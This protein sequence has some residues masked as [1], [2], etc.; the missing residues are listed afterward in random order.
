[1]LKLISQF[2][3]LNSMTITKPKK[4]KISIRIIA[5]LLIPSFV[6][7]T[8]PYKHKFTVTKNDP[9]KVLQYELSNGL[10]VYLSVNKDEPRISTNIALNTGSKNDPSEVTGLAHYLE[11]M[12]F[13]GTS[14]M[15]SLDWPKEKALLDQISAKYEEYRKT[16]DPAKRKTI[17]AEIDRLSGEAAKYVATNEYDQMIG[18]LGAK[19]TNAYTSLERTVYINDIPS[20]EL[21]KWM[22]IESE[23]FG[24]LTLR[25]FHTELEAV[26][27]E[28]NR[29]MD[30]DGRQANQARMQAL[31][32]N[33][34]YGTQ[35]TIGT[36]DHLKNPSMVKIHEYFNTYYVPNNMA[37]IMSGDLDPD[38]TIDLI[39]KYFGGM[40]MGAEP[41]Q[42]KDPGQPAIEKPQTIE[43]FGSEAEFISISYRTGG[44]ESGDQLMGDLATSVLSNG[45]A[46][47]IDKNMNQPQ[48]VI[49]AYAYSGG[50]KDYSQFTLGATPRA[51]QSLEEAQQLLL[52]QVELLKKGDFDEDLLKSIVRNAKK[53]QMQQAE[54]NGWKSRKMIDAFIYEMPWTYY[55]EYYNKMGEITKDKLVTWVNQKLQNN[56]IT[57]YKRQGERT[58]PKIEKP[59]I[60]PVTINR[61][62]KSDWRTNWEKT[63]SS[64]MTPAFINF[65]KDIAS[66]NVK[67]GLE[68]YYV[69]NATNSLFEVDYIFGMGSRND[70]KLAL[71][72]QYLPYLGTNKYSV[73]EI[74]RKFYDL[75]LN[76]SVFSGADRAYVSL[77]GLDESME[78]GMK[79]FEELLSDLKADPE[80]YSKMVDGII[81]KRTNAK[82]NKNRILYSA[83]RNYAFYGSNSPSLDMISEEELKSIDPNELVAKLKDL[84]NYKHRVFYYGP[85][86]KSSIIG[87]VKKHH[88]VGENLKDYPARKEYD[89]VKNEQNIVYFVDYDQ[90]QAEILM[91]SKTEKLNNSN[92]ALSSVFNQYF[93]SGLSSIVF[94]EIRESKALAYSAY[95]V[96]TNPSRKD[97]YHYVQAYIGTQNDKL[98]DAVAAMQELMNT[99]P[100]VENSFEQAKTGALKKMETS[101]VTKS[102]IYWTFQSA[103]DKGLTKNP[104]PEIYKNI[105]AITLDDLETFFNTNIKG[106]KYVYLVIGKKDLMDMEALKELGTVQE[107]DLETIFGY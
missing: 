46:G 31:F 73:E 64:R 44:I 90:V 33:H 45:K 3:Q 67:K 47:L 32:P 99:M 85:S 26:Y 30:N 49:R 93:G 103:Q 71:A 48:K 98:K 43:I 106:R 65:D 75:A 94:Q 97:D 70:K 10:K 83:M 58:T 11:H 22:M 41:K 56:Y 59:E 25:L 57:V 72:V 55:T 104:R 66:S 21:E 74:K 24:E 35:T 52:E 87:M 2:L 54:S 84:K 107:L 60:T 101:P 20:N 91:L 8:N 82:L 4:M 16:T 81:K 5:L 89:F 12:L 38:A 39:E 17:Y 50:M 96:Y 15:A 92:A 69:K 105:N 78:E 61:D 40:K 86:E 68:M 9:Y 7:A 28:F 34:T 100:K 18:Q 23:R 51:G 13:K 62:Q 29:G 80:A 76:Y 42:F 102:S 27:E 19:G 6:W 88:D 14:K 79:L 37:I 36:S 95:S 1:M 63:P 77:S 53:S